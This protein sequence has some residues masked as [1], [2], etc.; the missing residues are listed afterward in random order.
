MSISWRC[1]TSLNKS[2]LQKAINGLRT[3]FNVQDFTIEHH[4]EPQNQQDTGESGRT[5]TELGTQLYNVYACL[6]ERTLV[7][8]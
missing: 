6:A 1:I 2:N 4:E 8:T 5:K 7:F 3:K